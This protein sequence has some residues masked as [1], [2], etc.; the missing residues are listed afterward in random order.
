MFMFYSCIF[1]DIMTKNSFG[2]GF[3]NNSKKYIFMMLLASVAFDCNAMMSNSDGN[4]EQFHKRAKWG[5]VSLMSPGPMRIK[6]EDYFANQNMY[7]TKSNIEILCSFRQSL[8]LIWEKSSILNKAVATQSYSELLKLS[9]WQKKEFKNK[10]KRVRT[11]YTEEDRLQHYDDA[12]DF[13]VPIEV[14]SLGEYCFFQCEYIKSITIS[15]NVTCIEFYCFFGC[16]HLQEITIC[17]P[18]IIFQEGCFDL[19][20]SLKEIYVPDSTNIKEFE[21]KLLNSQT[22]LSASVKILP[23]S[24]KARR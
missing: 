17:N 10:F 18:D 22:G 5:T 16:T 11:I 12:P 6:F 4:L 19:C 7:N 2:T 23:I 21:R 1:V 8:L 14:T 9:E 24:K 20:N 3:L 15:Y 13:V